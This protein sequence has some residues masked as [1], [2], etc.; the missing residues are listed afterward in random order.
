MKFVI[1]VFDLDDTLYPEESF[2]FSGFSEVA[3]F[4]FNKVNCSE[5]EI[6]NELKHQYRSS[7][8]VRVFDAVL[9]K[10]GI[11]TESILGECIQIYRNHTP[12]IQLHEG[13][14]EVLEFFNGA[15]KY[16]VT[17]GN[18]LTQNNKVEALRIRQFFEQ[19]FTTWTFGLQAAKP[20]LEVFQKIAALEKS[21]LKQIVYIGDDPTKD[22]VSLNDVGAT[23]VRIRQ[24][25][26][27]NVQVED[28]YE[29]KFSIN[30]FID[31]KIVASEF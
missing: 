30:R 8:R 25:R 2:V 3:K 24:G 21:D 12:N 7:G 22:F 16:I 23:T 17:D 14:T 11:F 1:L 10:H 13:V 5:L 20:S 29:A 6:F 9:S 28:S 15:S 31:L 19:V 18:P 27:R 4:L 26:F